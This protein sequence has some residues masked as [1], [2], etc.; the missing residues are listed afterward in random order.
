MT[1]SIA[2]DRIHSLGPTSRTAVPPGARIVEGGGKF[3]IPGLWDMHCHPAPWMFPLF[4]ANGITGMRVLMGFP[5]HQKWRAEIS[6]GTRL[7]PRMTIASPVLDGPP[8]IDRSLNPPWRI[9]SNPEQGRMAVR[10]AVQEGADFIKV[11]ELLSRDSYFAIADEAQKQGVPFVG[12]VP[13][14]I[15]PVEC[16][17]AG[18]KSIEHVF[19]IERACAEG[20]ETWRQSLI[21]AANPAAVPMLDLRGRLETFDQSRAAAAASVFRKNHTWLCPTL[22]TGSG[23]AGDPWLTQSPNLRYVGRSHTAQWAKSLDD[24]ELPLSRRFVPIYNAVVAAMYKEGVGILAGTDPA[25][26][27][28]IPGFAVHEE[29]RFMVGAGLTPMDALRAA[30]YKPAE[31]LGK[32]DSLGTVERNKFAELV[33]L[34]ANPLDDIANTQK[35]NIVITE[36]RMFRKPALEATLRSAE[37]AA[38]K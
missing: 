8:G 7:G 22:V 35:I 3:L 14:Q 13:R 2:G 10:T 33:L 27:Y 31:F 12:H 38:R 23:I 18:Q 20:Y 1:V 26:P 24:P 5:V 9:V 21:R 34:E 37:A 25:L 29:L 30:T 15:T 4:L 17:M 36:G 32:L 28:C 19:G 6:A 11:Y 16:S